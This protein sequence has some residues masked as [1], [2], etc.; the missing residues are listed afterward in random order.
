MLLGDPQRQRVLGRQR[1]DA[2][3]RGLRG[4]L[5]RRR[6]AAEEPVARGLGFAATA[7]QRRATAASTSASA[8]RA[9]RDRVMRPPWRSG[10]ASM[11]ARSIRR[12][13]AT[14]RRQACGVGVR[15]GRGY[16]RSRRHRAAQPVGDLADRGLVDGE[17]VALQEVQQ[18][19]V[20]V[21]GRGANEGEA[22]L[23]GE[24]FGGPQ[25][26]ASDALALVLGVD[27]H[28]HD[29]RLAAVDHERH[30]ADELAVR[31]R[32]R[33]SRRRA[34]RRCARR[35]RPR[36]R[37]ERGRRSARWRRGRRPW[38]CGPYT[39]T[40]LGLDVAPARDRHV[41]LAERE[42]LA[43]RGAAVLRE[44]QVVLGSWVAP[45]TVMVDA[46]RQV[47]PV[48]GEHQARMMLYRFLPRHHSSATVSG[49]RQRYHRRMAIPLSGRSARR[50]RGPRARR[51][52]LHRPRRHASRPRGVGPPRRHGRTARSTP[53]GPSLT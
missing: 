51:G 49:T 17:A 42:V 5:A 20:V 9:K 28:E 7:R 45:W 33:G 27:A 22:A 52:A 1:A 11:R 16:P 6:R 46:C 35:R 39:S 25:Q 40:R 44:W 24:G 23:D 4:R 32:R 13:E 2:D 47:A 8:S 12:C 37:R 18:R 19:E 3:C 38:R 15:H 43:A 29:R 41:G 48:R 53:L 10:V 26:P 50:A 31:P 36:S 30:D 34:R 21:G 14:R